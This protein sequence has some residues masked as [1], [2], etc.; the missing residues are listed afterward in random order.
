MRGGGILVG[1][2]VSGT[3][4]DI[5]T[6]G[7]FGQGEQGVGRFVV[8]VCG[9]DFAGTLGDDAGLRCENEGIGGSN[10]GRFGGKR[11]V[12]KRGTYMFSKTYA[13]CLRAAS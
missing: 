7:N 2:C 12:C 13:S 6:F 10:M 9:D 1:C 8:E 3:G 4:V 11:S 5:C